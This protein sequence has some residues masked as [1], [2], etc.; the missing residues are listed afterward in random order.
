[1]CIKIPNLVWILIY[2]F[3]VKVSYRGI[4]GN[5]GLMSFT[6]FCC[7]YMLPIQKIKGTK[8]LYSAQTSHIFKTVKTINTTSQAN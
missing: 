2:C 8:R 1:M 7:K 6:Y 4:G 3:E 5:M